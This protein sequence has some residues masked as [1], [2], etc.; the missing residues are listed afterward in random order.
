MKQDKNIYDANLESEKY[1]IIILG[2]P[3]VGKTSL[4]HRF[5]KNKFLTNYKMTIGIE[6]HEKYIKIEESECILLLWDIAM[7][8]YPFKYI[9]KKV[10]KDVDGFLFVYDVTRMESFYSIS[11]C[12]AEVKRNDTE[13]DQKPVV[14]LGNKID[15]KSEKNEHM[16]VDQNMIAEKLNSLNIKNHFF[17]SARTGQ[18]V[19]KAFMSL[20]R[21]IYLK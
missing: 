17:T 14:L 6:T 7:F 1:Q 4:I 20:A 9:Q 10:Y 12:F 15:L 11:F 8:A 18:T 2:D 3:A 5:L 13:F 21:E 16:A 19:E